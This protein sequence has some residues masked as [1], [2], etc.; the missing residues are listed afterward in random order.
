MNNEEKKSMGAHNLIL[1]ERGSLT[2]TGVEDVDSF[3]EQTVVVYTGLG[4]LT[5]RG[6]QLHI[7][8]IDLQ[9]GELELQ[10]QVDSMTY[11]DQ[12]A[13]RGGFFARIFR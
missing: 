8:R 4:E 12:P 3:D 10:G 6:N 1:E 11:T 2:V 13:A 7:E 5:V 9:A